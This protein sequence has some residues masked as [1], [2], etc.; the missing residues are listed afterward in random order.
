L[1]FTE[2]T[3][4]LINERRITKN[5]LLTDLKL[6]KNSFV[7]WGK[8]AVPSGETISKIADYFNVSADYLLCRT[9]IKEPHLK[10]IAGEKEEV[11]NMKINT[12]AWE[13]L[14]I[15]VDLFEIYLQNPLYAKTIHKGGTAYALV[16]DDIGDKDIMIA[17]A[18]TTKD[19]ADRW[20][21]EHNSEVNQSKKLGLLGVSRANLEDW[22]NHNFN[23]P[24]TETQL[25][26]ML[27]DYTEWHKDNKKKKTEEILKF[28]RAINKYLN[29]MNFSE[30]S[31]QPDVKENV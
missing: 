28:K 20:L 26:N 8:G 18:T 27:E 24:P 30:A 4:S 6:G 1:S 12:E 14:E 16:I 5:K 13:S 31:G 25:R 9:D 2:R 15:L 3:L 21:S 23:T 29:F 7:D 10:L 19:I 22:K 17:K 11:S